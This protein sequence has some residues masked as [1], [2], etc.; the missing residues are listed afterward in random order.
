MNHPCLN[1]YIDL[2]FFIRA[3]HEI[4]KNGMKIKYIDYICNLIVY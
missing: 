3:K 4:P 1:S 2:K